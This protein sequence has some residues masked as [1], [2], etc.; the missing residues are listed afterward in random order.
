MLFGAEPEWVFC[1][2][3]AGMVFYNDQKQGLVS[4][5]PGCPMALALS[6]ELLCDPP[7]MVMVT[8]K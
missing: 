8:F 5:T 1:V 4:E 6:S 3:A 7:R 2:L